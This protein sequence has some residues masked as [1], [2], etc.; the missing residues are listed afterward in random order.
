[1]NQA[2][3]GLAVLLQYAVSAVA[4]FRLA[5]RSE[6]GLGIA[7]RIVAP[8]TLL[9]IFALARSAKLA[10]AAIL[11][12]ILLVGLLLVRL[13]HLLASARPA[14]CTTRSAARP[15]RPRSAV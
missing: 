10:E 2:L 6:R 5:A 15:R 4:L 1:M 14:R 11:A 7:D 8:L 3:I 9:S 12:G 13:R